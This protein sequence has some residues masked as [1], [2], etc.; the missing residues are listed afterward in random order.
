MSTPKFRV[1]LAGEFYSYE[2]YDER[3]REIFTL[4]T[5]IAEAE[6]QFGSDWVSVYNG[7]S[8]AN[9]EDVTSD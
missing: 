9:R 2:L 4:A 1:T 6:R 5:A 7:E 8:S 3:G